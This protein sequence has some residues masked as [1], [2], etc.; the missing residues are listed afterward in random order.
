MKIRFVTVGGT[1]DKVYFDALSEYQV[2]APELNGFCR[3]CQLLL[4][5]KLSLF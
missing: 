3:N 2:G 1:I 5:T 4:N